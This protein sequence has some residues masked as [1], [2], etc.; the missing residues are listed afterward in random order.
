M[1][2]ENYTL[3]RAGYEQMQREL[4]ALEKQLVQEIAEV[5]EAQSDVKTDEEATLFDAQTTKERVQER[6]SHLR[7]V[8]QTA[9]VIDADPDPDRVSPGDRVVVWDLDNKEELAFDLLGGEEIILG[10]KGISI[11]APVGQAL[12]NHR[13]GDKVKVETPDGEAR[14]EV[15]RL[16]EIPN[17]E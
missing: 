10:R 13:V 1:A 16:E 12:L 6:V 14:Y 5:A 7:L 17:E 9:E 15:R 8:L 3:T 11:D 2:Q 4:E